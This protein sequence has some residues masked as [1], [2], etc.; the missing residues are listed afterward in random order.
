[1]YVSF[2][3]THTYIHTEAMVDVARML[4]VMRWAGGGRYGVLWLL[5]HPRPGYVI[6]LVST[7]RGVG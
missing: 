6:L 7:G 2:E 4:R 1:M 5:P 3:L